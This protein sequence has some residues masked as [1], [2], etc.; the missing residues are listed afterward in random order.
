M[1]IGCYRRIKTDDDDILLESRN[2]RHNHRAYPDTVDLQRVITAMQQTPEL[3]NA[4]I[5]NIDC[6]E[7]GSLSDL[8]MFGAMQSFTKVR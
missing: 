1:K 4:Y 3:E 7:T 6:Q 2:T 8:S 5:G